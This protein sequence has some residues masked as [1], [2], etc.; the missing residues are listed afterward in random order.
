M[1]AD[2][3]AT[4]R[5]RLVID[6]D[7]SNVTDFLIYL[8]GGDT[9]A[10]GNTYHKIISRNC[11]QYVPLGT[12]VPVVAENATLGDVY[13]GAYREVG[14]K[15]YLLYVSRE[16]LMFDFNVVIGDSIPGYS[17]NL[18]VTAIDSIQLSGVYHKRYHTTDT[19]YS[20]IEGV[21][22]SRGLM[23]QLVDGT[24]MANFIC[25]T[26]DS[27]YYT[28]DASIPCTYIYPYGYISGIPG[29]NKTG[30]IKV[31]PVS[32]G[33][34][35]HVSGAKNNPALAVIYDCTG[36]AIWNGNISGD[37]EISVAGWPR[38]VYYMRYTGPGAAFGTKK[39]VLE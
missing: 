9:V 19:G 10:L 11:I 21:G 36:R 35:L 17:G 29:V 26:Y 15:I 2:S 30:E 3:G 4:W 18:M 23:P 32:T 33:D 13:Y 27:V 28:P 34:L 31:F 8:N 16:V 12:V 37:R 6:D 1:P 39:I 38:G 14:K 22:S 20:V 5:Y 25:F 24:G 7:E